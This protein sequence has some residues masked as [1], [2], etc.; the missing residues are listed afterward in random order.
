MGLSAVT[1][2]WPLAAT[3]IERAF[4]SIGSKP[5]AVGCALALAAA[6]C[7]QIVGFDEPHVRDAGPSAGTEACGLP[8]GT[9]SCASCVRASC[10]SESAACE[11]DPTCAPYEACAGACAGDPNCRAHCEIDHPPGTSAK[12]SALAACLADHCESACGLTCGAL[13]YGV[14]PDDAEPCQICITTNACALSRACAS[15]VDCDENMRCRVACGFRYDCI[16]ACGSAHPAGVDA[17]LPISSPGFACS[18]ACGRGKDW[19]CVG[20]L[21][22]SPLPPTTPITFALQVV[23]FQ[24]AGVPLQGVNVS[25]CPAYNPNPDCP[26]PLAPSGTTDAT[27]TVMFQL[28]PGS[29]PVNGY[30]RLTATPMTK[31]A[32][33]DYYWGFPLTETN[34]ALTSN[35]HSTFFGVLVLAGMEIDNLTK[36]LGVTEDPA[37]GHVY[38]SPRDCLGYQAPHV[39]ITLSSADLATV[40][41]YNL[42]PTGTEADSAGGAGFFNV[43]SG[44]TEITI[45]PTVL[46]KPA[47]KVIV[48]VNAGA[49]DTVVVM[50]GNFGAP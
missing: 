6:G 43:P 35:G 22:F 15:S 42:S 23:D 41:A 28:V 38:V 25:V 50:P 4:M 29:S 8:Y 37:R 49:L 18:S 21:A 2:C 39:Q 30:A 16:E 34:V 40:R 10:C 48:P 47:Q 20:H 26:Y 44:N 33:T 3:G 27:G 12:G 46:G 11:L 32:P 19:N 17:S 31:I 7:R 45:T 9:A 5:V 36:S 24:S 14:Q 1:N 13:A